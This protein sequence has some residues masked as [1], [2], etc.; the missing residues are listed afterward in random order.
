M[1]NTL[2]IT[3]NPKTHTKEQINNYTYQRFNIAKIQISESNTKSIY[4]A[5]FWINIH[6]INYLPPGTPICKQ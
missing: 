2:K 1:T 5:L 4:H 3:R 6:H